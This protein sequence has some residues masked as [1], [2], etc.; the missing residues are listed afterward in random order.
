MKKFFVLDTNVLLHDPR[1]I[2]SFK[3]NNVVIIISVLGE[4]DNFKKCLGE[5]GAN[6]RKTAREIDFISKKHNL[7]EGIKMK[8]GGKLFVYPYH[9]VGVKI[10][11]TETVDGHILNEA[12]YLKENG[13][14]AVVV[15]KDTILRIIANGLDIQAEDYETDKKETDDYSGI[16]ELVMSDENLCSF[17]SQEYVDVEQKGMINQYV[18]I[19]CASD[20][21]KTLIG[22]Y[23]DSKRIVLIKSRK[24]NLVNIYPKN[25]EQTFAM[26]A[27]LDDEIKLVTL[28]GRSGTGKTLL[29]VAAGIA[30][31]IDGEYSKIIV[32]RPIVPVGKDLG[33]L[34]GT[35]DEKMDP[36]M[37]PIYDA[38]DFIQE[39]D[40]KS[41][42]SFISSKFSEQDIQVAPLT[43][44]R[45]RSIPHSFI[46]ADESQNLSPLE[47]KTLITRC[48]EGTKMV[49]TGDTDQIDNPFLD[50]KSNGF[51]YL[52]SKFKGKSIHAHVYLKAG[53]RSP[54]A[55]LGSQIL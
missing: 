30:K 14:H 20:E 43:Y 54:L 12:K 33:F 7:F 19:K 24:P 21:K 5:L 32:T 40:R 39:V 50:S 15:S 23:S 36:W 17:M 1:S 46:V 3:D 4:L 8:S 38:I 6:A 13:N 48:G 45:G 51:S 53:E 49:F 31:F 34:P 41:G 28:Q 18:N 47:V 44:V 35:I 16:T 10:N 52:I 42:R 22:K 55:E 9:D 11:G 25:I 26:D 27:L 29:A 2:F 37:R